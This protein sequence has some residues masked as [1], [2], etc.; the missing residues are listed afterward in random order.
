MLGDWVGAMITPWFINL[1]IL[2]GGGD[3]W[4]DRPS[5]Q[6]CHIVFPVGPL[7]FIADDDASAEVPAFQY[8]PLFAP[9]G[10]FASQAAARAAAI[11][12]LNAMFGTPA[13]EKEEERATSAAA[14]APKLLLPARRSFLRRVARH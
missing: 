4:S 1:L 12:A 2:P 3:L 7:E 14:A 10:Q 11:A 6:R 8:C 5:G 13:E 9:P